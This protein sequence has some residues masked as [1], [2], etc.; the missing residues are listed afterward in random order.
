MI[1]LFYW[2][3]Y[4][5][6]IQFYPFPLY[7]L[8]LLCTFY[9]SAVTFPYPFHATLYH[10]IFFYF[11][12]FLCAFSTLLLLTTPFFSIPPSPITFYYFSSSKILY[13]HKFTPNSSPVSSSTYPIYLQMPLKPPPNQLFYPQNYSQHCR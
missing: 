2:N 6:E 11:Y 1:I 13:H 9:F 12:F 10:S 5:I 4:S 8:L 7:S 3:L